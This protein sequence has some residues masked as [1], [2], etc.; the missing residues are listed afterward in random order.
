MLTN[1]KPRFSTIFDTVFKFRWQ[2]NRHTWLALAAGIV[3]ILL[4]LAV[5]LYF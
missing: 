4:S 2:P 5:I 1:P 3:V